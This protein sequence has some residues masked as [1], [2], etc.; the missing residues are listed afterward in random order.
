MGNHTKHHANTVRTAIRII[1]VEVLELQKEEDELLTRLRLL[2][3]TITLKFP[4]NQLPNEILLMCFRLAVQDWVDTNDAADQ[5]ALVLYECG[6]D[7]NFDLPCTPVFAISHISHH[8]RQ[9]VINTPSLWTNLII[10]QKFEHHLDVFRDFLRRANGLPIATI[11]RLFW[12][13]GSTLSSAGVSLIDTIIPLIHAQQINALTFLASTSALS[14]LLS[15]TITNPPSPPSVAFGCLTALSIFESYY[16]MGLTFSQLRQL[17]SAAP[18]LQ[19]LKLQHNMPLS[20]AERADKTGIVLPMLQS[21]TIIQSNPLVCKIIDSLSAPD[22]RQL[23]LL[24]WDLGLR[25]PKF[26]KVQDLTL[27]CA[28]R[29]GHLNTNLIIAF[30][31]VTHLTLNSPNLFC[32]IEGPGSLACPTF[33]CLQHLT[34]DFPFGGAQE[35]DW[36]GCFAWLPTPEER[37]DR[38]L[39]ISVFDRSFEAKLYAGQHL[40]PYYEELQQYRT[41]DSNSTRLDEF[42]CWQAMDNGEPEEAIRLLMLAEYCNHE[43]GGHLTHTHG[44]PSKRDRTLRPQKYLLV[45]MCRLTTC[46]ARLSF[47]IDR[48]AL[49][50]QAPAHF[51]F[52]YARGIEQSVVPSADDNSPANVPSPHWKS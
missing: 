9:L 35:V 33:Q 4:V 41:L 37:A 45:P 31:R 18:Q 10:T 17:L 8:W 22:V 20:A 43:D 12:Q 14:Y 38:P 26:P 3:D 1:E 44:P 16:R 19:T 51:K 24:T 32:E 29:Y 13:S 7:A 5:R 47:P 30:P 23:K 34:L 25:M 48:K 6:D 36:R 40:F 2:Q 11:F 27:S 15:R 49:F 39:L 28:Y 52:D 50:P 21:L 46:R 42:M